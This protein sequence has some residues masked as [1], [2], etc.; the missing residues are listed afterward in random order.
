MEKD[1]GEAEPEKTM[2]PKSA[3][4]RNQIKPNETKDDSF[5]LLPWQKAAIK[6]NQGEGKTKMSFKLTL[7]NI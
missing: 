5:K 4:S 7:L 2:P 6:S 3:I 1:R